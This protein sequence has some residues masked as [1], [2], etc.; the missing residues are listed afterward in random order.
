VNRK[1]ESVGHP[2]RAAGNFFGRRRAKRL[3]PEQAEARN[4][5]LPKFLIDISARPPS[6]PRSLTQLFANQ[7]DRINLEIGFGGGEHLL[8]RATLD[9]DIGFI[10]CEPFINGMARAAKGIE[11]GKI[12]NIRLYD[13]DATELLDWLPAQSLQRIDLLY[14]DPWPKKRHWKRRFLNADN[15]N[16]FHRVLAKG[17]E[18][19][20][21]SDIESYV[22]WGLRH[23]LDHG[24]FAWTANKSADWHEPWAE[25]LST[26]YEQ[27]AIREGRTPCYMI[28]EKLKD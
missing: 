23:M 18:F 6:S 27:K 9:P 20:F 7:P 21:A 11:S 22:N 24:G 14:P 25:W 26:R 17:G 2:T 5:V 3:K 13:E 19:R 8:H 28:F 4:A 15:V 12:E 16:R 1:S 10:G